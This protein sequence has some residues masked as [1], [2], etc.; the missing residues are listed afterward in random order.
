[1]KVNLF[2]I[3]LC[4]LLPTAS[5]QAKEW[6]GIVP[7]KSTR[8]DVE[9][10]LGRPGAHGRYQFENE[11]VYVEY[12]KGS[13]A[14]VDDCLCLVPKDTVLSIRVVLEVEMRFSALKLDKAKYKKQVVVA[15][16]TQATYTNDEE[17]IIY[18]VDEVNDDVIAIEYLPTD[19][20]CR[21][22]TKR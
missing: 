10:L 19:R 8:V 17:G 20:E 14:Q 22:L 13:C 9:R 4:L 1:M 15:D 5:L 16:A 11:R 6:R 12:S 7:L 21:D 2:G 3:F 18:T